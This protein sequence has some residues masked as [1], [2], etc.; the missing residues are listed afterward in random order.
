VTNV[1]GDVI[2]FTYDSAVRLTSITN[3]SGLETTNIYYSSG[4]YAG[5]LQT[6]IDGG[7]RT[8]GFAYTN[9]NILT[10]TNELGLVKTYTWDELNRLT[11]TKFPDG[12][13]L[14]N[15]YSRLDRVSFKDRMSNWTQ[16]V[17]NDLR[18]LTSR[19]NANGHATVYEYCDCGALSSITEQNG[20]SP[21]TTLL[22]YDL[23]GRRTKITYPDG[24]VQD[25]VYD[26][27]S[28]FGP[29]RIEDST[30]V[31]THIEYANEGRVAKIGLSHLPDTTVDSYY[32]L[33]RTFDQYGRVAQTVD[34]NGVTVTN[35]YDFLDRLTNRTVLAGGQPRETN[36]FAYTARGLTNS[37]DAK[38]YTNWF[39]YDVAG[40][41][42]SQTNANGEDLRFTYNAAD[43]ILSLVDGKGQTTRWN[44]D[45]YGRATNKVDAANAEIF[46]YTYDPNARLTNRWTAQ[47]GD[48]IYRYD[49]VG[50]LTNVDYPGTAMDIIMQY[51]VLDRLTNVIDAVGTIRFTHNNAGQ[52]LSEDGPWADDTV[53]YSYSAR[54]R[55]GISVA[56]PN[57]SAWTQSYGYDHYNRLTNVTSL[58]GHFGYS[59]WAPLS[60]RVQSLGLPGQG[61]E[62]THIE[63]QF[64]SLARL[65]GTTLYK[66]DGTTVLNQHTYQYND[67]NERTR[68]TFKEGNYVDYT[69]D[70][71]GQ[72]KTAMGWEAGGTTNR[73]QEQFGYAYD[74]AWN[75]NYRTNNALTQTF[76]VN[77]L[78]ELTTASRSGTFTVAGTATERKAAYEGDRGVTNVTVSGT[79]LSSGVA[80]IYADGSWA[81]TNASLVNGIN[82]YTATAQDYDGR[83]SQDSVSVNL[84][85]SPTF[86]YDANGNLTNDSQRIFEYDFENQLTNV[87]VANGWRSEFKYDAFGRRRIRKEYTWSGSW[88]QTNEVRYVYDSRLAVHERDANNLTLVTYTRG[89]DLS[90]TLQGAGGIGGLLARTDHDGH[91]YYHC[92]GGGNVTAM[93]N[94]NGAMI[95][96][97][98]YDPCGNILAM[99][100]PLAEANLYRF[101]SKETHRVSGMVY[102]LHR[103]YQPKVQRWLNRDPIGEEGGVSLF[104]Y[105]KN[106]PVQHVDAFGLRLVID[107]KAP[108][109][110]RNRMR[111]CLQN[112]INK[113]PKGLDL[114]KEAIKHPRT[115]TISPDKE[116]AGTV[117]AV[118]SK[119]NAVWPQNPTIA[120]HPKSPNGM[121]PSDYKEAKK[122]GEAPPNNLDGCSLALA[123]ELGHALYDYQEPDNVPKI[124]NVVRRDLDLPPRTTYH[125]TPL[126]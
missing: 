76:S 75:L 116:G 1:A 47:K 46:R 82:S 74:K 73:L 68:Q 109:T 8:N 5:F 26:I 19:T 15:V 49:P 123:H 119:N 52:L 69:Y 104:G 121:D 124:E 95:A 51:D 70:P 34:R 6:R 39:V 22:D 12:T 23:A 114:V 36:R 96:R 2:R 35:G 94:A 63:N 57:A 38:G 61:T 93:V 98:H 64:D 118:T 16:Y 77:N 88:V 20:G 24:F 126:P 30:G 99:A 42:L 33:S 40:R 91:A 9:G 11:S 27:S 59:Y 122:V 65:T 3:F 78:N 115:I 107:P 41:L 58:A 21:L 100:G 18:Q 43:Q 71:I 80:D 113:S 56:Q 53:S 86:A 28:H 97:Y 29:V 105:V 89:D 103:Y 54:R 106:N 90:G 32:L 17:Y 72:L 7:F 62:H 66:A 13:T 83:T 10:R 4:N 117:G 110:F 120:M 108:K 125:G 101:S 85:S 14:S 102:Y 31:A 67:A 50:N 84:P 48:T 25:Y 55:A 37:V 87:Y 60:D 111:D 44:Y 79:G 112:L 92:D 45:E 81:R